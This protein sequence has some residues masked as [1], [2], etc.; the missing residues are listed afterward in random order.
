VTLFGFCIEIN[1][2]I[3]ESAAW[4]LDVDDAFNVLHENFELE[5]MRA[6]DENAEWDWIELAYFHNEVDLIWWMEAGEA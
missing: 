6:L 5:H 1:G 4:A 3:Y 2:E